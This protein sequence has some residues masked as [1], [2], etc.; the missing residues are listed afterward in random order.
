MQELIPLYLKD[1]EVNGQSAHF[2]YD[3]RSLWE[4]QLHTMIPNKSVDSLSY[5]DFM[6][7]MEKYKDMSVS[8]RNRRIAYLKTAYGVVI[9]TIYTLIV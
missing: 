3:F 8:T 1:R 2:I 4:N 6:S 7:I 9:V 5:M